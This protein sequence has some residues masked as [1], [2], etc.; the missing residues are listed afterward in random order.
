MSMIS[1]EG[2]NFEYPPH[3]I[4]KDINFE[5]KPGSVTALVG[6]NGAGKTTLLRCLTNLE[7]PVSGKIHIDGVDIHRNP[8]EAHRKMGYLS[9]FFGLY[10]DLTVKQCLTYM[11]W[12]QKIPSEQIEHKIQHIAEDVEIKEYLDKKAGSLSRGYRQRLG[13]GLSMIHEPKILLLDEPASGMDPE[14]RINLSEFIVRL[15][16]RGMTIIVSS[17]ILA[18]LEDYCTDMLII[19][20]GEIRS[21]VVLEEHQ[22][23]HEVVVEI[24][25]AHVT[26]DQLKVVSSHEHVGRLT[27]EENKVY[28]GFTGG[29]AEQANFLKFLLEKGLPVHSFIPSQKTLKSAYMDLAETKAPTKEGEDVA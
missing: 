5:L 12:C 9:D 23:E 22:A 24:G 27:S 18:E 15:Q 13:V 19:R 16:Q 10:D 2:L 17:H 20:D 29:Q 21:H 28:C 1:V 8:R 11:A 26:Q 4:L 3:H 14:A 25:I 7:T 6:P